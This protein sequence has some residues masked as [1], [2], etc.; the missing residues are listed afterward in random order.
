MNKKEF[1]RD[2]GG[3]PS[4]PRLYPITMKKI[5][6]TRTGADAVV[7]A[8]NEQL[9][10]GGGVCGAIFKAAGSSMLQ[11]S[12]DS[13]G[14]C[15]TGDAVITPGYNLSRYIIHA[16]GPI[17]TDGKHREPQLLYSCY[18]KSLDLARDNGCASIAFPLISAGIFGYPADKAFR[19]A[20]QACK[21]WFDENEEVNLH[22]I[23]AVPE[24]D[25]YDTGKKVAKSLN[26]ELM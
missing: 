9:L 16:V 21:D 10:Q 12:C 18:K 11:Q 17:Y 3:I 14:H 26:I 19:K 23:F 22:I 1:I 6:I 20:F 5:G 8:A 25:K 24:D 4:L 13:I 7:N 2:C 15:G